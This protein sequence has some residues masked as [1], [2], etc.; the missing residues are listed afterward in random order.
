MSGTGRPANYHPLVGGIPRAGKSAV[1]VA[2]IERTCFRCDGEFPCASR[3][4]RVYCPD[5]ARRYGFPASTVQK[6]QSH[7]A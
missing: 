4:R 7:A 6:G 1:H 5:C 2:V 3:E